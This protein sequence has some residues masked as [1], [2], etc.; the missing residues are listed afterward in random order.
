LSDWQPMDTAPRGAWIAVRSDDGEPIAAISDE[1]D[2]WWEDETGDYYVEAAANPNGP[3]G[4]THWDYLPE[5][6]EVLD[7]FGTNRH[8]EPK[9]TPDRSEQIEK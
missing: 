8:S 5:D 2:G 4:L 1:E 9:A 7:W 6:Y 3:H